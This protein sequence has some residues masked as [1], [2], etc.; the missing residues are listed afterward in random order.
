MCGFSEGKP[1][2][3][4]KFMG[5]NSFGT[6]FRVTTWGESHGPAIG[7][8]ID[9]CPAGLALTEMDIQKKLDLRI[10]GRS[11]QVSERQEK[12]R[13]AILSGVFEGKTTGAPIAL[14]IQNTD[15]NTAAYESCKEVLRPGHA[16]FTY[17]AKYG[18]FDY[19][20]GG[21]ASARET[22][23]RVAAGAVAE[24]L[25]SLAGVRIISY[26][27]AVGEYSINPNIEDI[28]VFE[29]A[30]CASPLFCPEKEAEE[31]M[32]TRIQAV[33]QEGDSIGGVVECLVLH[34][35]A[36]LGDPV[37]EKLEAK[38][39]AA[40]MSLPASK[41]FEIGDGYGAAVKKGSTHND[42]FCI[43]KE[44][45]CVHTNHAGGL[46]GGITTGAPLVLRT[47]FKPASSIQKTQPT[48]D[49]HGNP[50]AFCLGEMSRHDPCVAVRAVPVCAAMCGLVCA[51]AWL[52][53]KIAKL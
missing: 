36:G 44:K 12:D 26:L 23:C 22:A 1:T 13:V 7:C 52:M 53:G 50:T 51:D 2:H 32:K 15:A 31:Q 21:R 33:K 48:V 25:L 28:D 19:R 20:G 11:Y 30:I 17:L 42:L 5:S 41:G 47:H 4:I 40:M 27:K 16:N 49:I 9:G 10:P 39:A 6:L 38:L 8:V 29:A 3:D 37:Y 45:V 34:L 14:H 18:I 43:E 46:L 35:P 24:K